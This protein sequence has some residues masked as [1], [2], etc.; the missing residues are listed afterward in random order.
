[1]INRKLLKQAQELQSR[2]LKAQEEMTR[3]TVEAS[4]GGGAVTVV[5]TGQPR[6]K[7]VRISPEAA[8]DPELLPDLIVAAVNEALN[9]AQEM[10][11]RHMGGLGIP[12]L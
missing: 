8:S 11:S 4:V 5:M 12:G 6:V 7:E 3:L 10:A 1:M 2:I 9:K